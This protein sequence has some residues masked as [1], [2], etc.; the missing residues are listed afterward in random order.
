M[1]AGNLRLKFYKSK[2]EVEIENIECCSEVVSMIN[3]IKKEKNLYSIKLEKKK[4]YETKESA[5]RSSS[6]LS[7]RNFFVYF[8]VHIQEKNFLLGCP[9]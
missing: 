7:L 1:T 5:V 4:K 6:F 2:Y 8:E 3:W 9:L